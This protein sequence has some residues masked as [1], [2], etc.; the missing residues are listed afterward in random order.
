[1]AADPNSS[2]PKKLP[3]LI[4]RLLSKLTTRLDDSAQ[5][6]LKIT[7][8][9]L[10]IGS[11]WILLSDRLVELLF[12]QTRSIVLASIAKG[13]FYVLA[14]S[15]LIYRLIY[16]AFK[17]AQLATRE[18]DQKRLLQKS[19]IDS[20]PDLIFYK[21]R[22]G[23]YLGCN[24]AFEKFVGVSEAEIIGCQ[25][26]SFFSPDTALRFTETDQN[27][28]ES[29]SALRD[30]MVVT[31]RDGRLVYL[32][33]VKTP[34]YDTSNQVIGLIGISRDI[35]VEKQKGQQ[36]QYLN[37]HDVLTGLYNRTYFQEALERLDKPE[38]HPISVI[39]GDING[40]KLIND[41]LGHVAGDNILIAIA[42]ILHHCSRVSDIVARTGGDEFTILLP[43][44]D[45]EA[46]SQIV[47]QIKEACSLY[48][49]EH[50]RETYYA[51][52]SLGY[53]T[54]ETVHDTFAKA[55]KLAVDYMVKRK[56]LEH[57][58]L[59][60][61]IIASIKTTMF[62][63]SNE[64]EAHAERIAVLAKQLGEALGL[65]DDELVALEL[66]S[67]LHDI[68]KIGV[69]LNILTK[70]GELSESDWR[71]IKRHPEI[72]YRITQAAPELRHISDFI[73]CHHERWDG[74]GYPQGLA[75][76]DIPLLSRI[77]S[78]V[79]SYDAMTEDR[80][81]RKALPREVA[82]AKIRQGS[83]SQFDPAIVDIFLKQVVEAV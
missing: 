23:N 76:S 32:D 60:S 18:S 42:R 21:D 36:I 12:V 69:D 28:L 2:N 8:I 14:T 53:A 82:I 70:V 13:W 24:H 78:I 37:Y 25:A 50:D 67:T 83:G 7:L 33:T 15:Y 77:L 39:V 62:E 17:R 45:Q 6:A 72:G 49:T 35:T 54:K 74:R 22:V 9:Y 27:I 73:L 55:M 31:T 1:M 11:L 58:S 79:D 68:G 4:I 43:N 29:E 66:L 44:T 57:K 52:I 48:A 81:Y 47:A 41:T 5:A 30:E 64:T 34:Y 59:H 56:L 71:E 3:A 16:P 75:G 10:I 20:I 38:H 80:T 63:K 40:L 61:S 26:A 51:D 46:S 65:S 19:M